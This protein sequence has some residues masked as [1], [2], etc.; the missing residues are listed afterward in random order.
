MHSGGRRE[1]ARPLITALASG[2]RGTRAHATPATKYGFYV[3]AR[4]KRNQT[5]QQIKTKSIMSATAEN[6]NKN[7]TLRAKIPSNL[8]HWRLPTG[9]ARA[10]GRNGTIRACDWKPQHP[11]SA[12]KQA[13][14]SVWASK[15][16]VGKQSWALRQANG[17]NYT[18]VV[19][20][21]D[22]VVI[23]VV[24]CGAF[25]KRVCRFARGD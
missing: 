24:R 13:V 22:T 12:S 8:I 15:N 25:P 23:V 7:S 19:Y 14:I 1:R 9:T 3:P 17:A 11:L 16:N 18:N 2:T 6:S 5:T 20:V 4:T 10:R 21:I